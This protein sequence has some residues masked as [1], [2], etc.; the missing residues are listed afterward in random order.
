MLGARP[1]PSRFVYSKPR[2][3]LTKEAL[4]AIPDKFSWLEKG[5]MTSIKFQGTCGSCWAFA[6]AGVMEALIKRSDGVEVDLSEQQ[7]VNCVPETYGCD[8][9]FGWYAHVYMVNSGIV[10]ESVYP[11]QDRDWPCD[12]TAPSEFYLTKAWLY[13]KDGSETKLERRQKIKHIIKTYGPVDTVLQVYEDFYRNYTSGVYIYDGISAPLFFHGGVIAGWKNDSA[14]P[15]GGYWII[16]NDWGPA[17]GENGYFRI[18]YD[19]EFFD[20][21]EFDIRYGLY[22]GIGND[23]PYFNGLEN[24]YDGREGIELVISNYAEDPDGTAIIYSA[25]NTPAGMS[26]DASTGIISWTPRYIQAGNHT[27]T[28]SISDGTYSFHRLVTL[29]IKNV[30][31]I[32]R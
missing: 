25:E 21:I 16:K 17:W 22:N 2:I 31:K 10:R 3:A 26:I 24:E 18:A 9:G 6:A 32:K 29:N 27:F 4:Q 13:M 28:I 20:I 23:P 30:K 7:L 12:L 19:S 11:Y 1:A 14:V 5:I 8:G 15:T